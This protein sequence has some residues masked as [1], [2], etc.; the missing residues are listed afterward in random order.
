MR[1]IYGEDYETYVEMRK[2]LRLV[3]KQFRGKNYIYVIKPDSFSLISKG[4]ITFLEVERLVYVG[5]ILGIDVYVEPIL[6]KEK[7]IDV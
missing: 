3:V 5:K 6:V 7:T 1:K 2:Q 4:G